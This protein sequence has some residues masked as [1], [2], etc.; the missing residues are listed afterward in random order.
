MTKVQML[1][2]ITGGRADGTVWPNAGD[3]LK[4]SAAE[5]EDLYR[6]QLARPWPGGDEDEQTAEAA[7]AAQTAALVEAAQPPVQWPPAE[8]GRFA[9]PPEAEAKTSPEDVADGDETTPDTPRPAASKSE[10]VAH[11][12][13]QGASEEEANAATKADLQER[14]GARP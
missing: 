11:A 7:A 10:W 9:V 1:S 5:A 3:P 14:Y 4:V 6:A 13:S 2:H 12:V 8:P